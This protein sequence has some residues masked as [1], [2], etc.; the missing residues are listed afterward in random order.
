MDVVLRPVNERFLTEVAFPA[1]EVG[2]VDATAGISQLLEHVQSGRTRALLESLA[3]SGVEGSFF[4]LAADAWLEA[5]Y[6]LVFSV[7]RKEPSGWEC[8]SDADGGM[9][10]PVGFAGDWEEALHLALMIEHPQYAYWVPHMAKELRLDTVKAPPREHG[11]SSFLCGL[12][13]PF[14]S[15]GPDQVLSTRG[16]GIYDPQAKE[17]IA[18][19]SYRSAAVVR[20]WNEELPPKLAR[21]LRRETDRL[22]SMRPQEADG[23]F[24]FWAGKLREPPMLPVAFSGLGPAAVEWIR[25]VGQLAEQLRLATAAGLGLTCVVTP[26]GAAPGDTEIPDPRM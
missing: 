3:E 2:V 1:F 8:L 14:P 7:W 16:A 6:R 24:D 15:F 25:R 9:G 19:W 18:D 13:D 20:R 5:V 4:G 10:G 12:W 21:L 22:G 23:I 17:A 11:L 26:G